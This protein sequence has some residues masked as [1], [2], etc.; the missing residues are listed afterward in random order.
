MKCTRQRCHEG[1]QHFGDGRL[2]T[3]M[4]IGDH[5]LN[6]AQA[7]SGKLAQEL[8]PEGL[9]LRRPDVHAE[10]FAPAVA[11]DSDRDDDRCGY[12]TPTL[13]HLHVSRIDP[14]IGPV[15]FDRAAQEGLHL[16]VDLL[17][18]PADLALGDAAHAHGFDEIIDRA[19][20]DAMHIGLLHDRGQSLL[21]QAAG[22]QE[23]REVA[24]FPQLGNAQ[25]HRAGTRLPQPIAIA[26][27]L[28]DPLR[29]ALAMGGTGHAFDLKGHQALG[30][31]A[32]HL[33]QQI[34]VG[35]LFQKRAKAH[36]LVGHRWILSS[37]AWFSD[38]TLP[39]IRDDHR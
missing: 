25:L 34:G 5:Q 18:Q 19:G 11:V 1:V 17:A 33:P 23:G 9:G 29:T 14:Q 21:G 12:D 37:V 2:D 4:R 10:D 20:R 22:L 6:A 26:I 36:H 24:A 38:Q 8:G 27:A 32:N 7:A 30:G 31:E 39:M 3:F 35:T 16:L 28:G 13:A 15:A